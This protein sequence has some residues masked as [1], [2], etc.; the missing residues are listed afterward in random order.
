MVSAGGFGV[1]FG[2]G[3]A[4]GA[5]FCLGALG[6]RRLFKT[7]V[8]QVFVHGGVALFD[9]DIFAVFVLVL[10]DCLQ[11]LIAVVGV[12]P[13]FELL[14]ELVDDV[15]GIFFETALNDTLVET[16]DAGMC[17]VNLE[18]VFFHGEAVFVGFSTDN[19]YHGHVELL[20]FSVALF[21][22]DVDFSNRIEFQVRET[23]NGIE[24]ASEAFADNV[25]GLGD[26]LLYGREIRHG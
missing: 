12:E 24:S 10:T 21:E 3:D 17:P 9:R 18:N 19:I 2:V 5:F 11:S 7:G 16:L 20:F 1:S 23:P 26:F 6:L 22:F 4:V 14:K 8:N 13:D 15:G 25:N